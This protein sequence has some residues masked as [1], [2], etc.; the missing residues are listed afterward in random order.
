[1]FPQQMLPMSHLQM[2]HA[3]Q[4]P[5]QF[6]QL[7][8]MAYVLYTGCQD[9]SATNLACE[10]PAARKRPWESGETPRK[11]PAWRSEETPPPPSTVR[12][13]QDR[14]D[15]DSKKEKG[16]PSLKGT[17]AESVDIS[18][19]RTTRAEDIGAVPFSNI[20]L[21]FPPLTSPISQATHSRPTPR[22]HFS[23]I[24][25]TPRPTPDM[26]PLARGDPHAPNSVI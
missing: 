2:Q 13:Y 15:D 22:T 8:P 14:E 12:P 20:D 17:V 25:S 19:K 26:S 3:M 11:R 10:V 24:S 7:A 4:L 21:F 16:A 23:P 1:M 6:G 18:S 9:Q 5:M